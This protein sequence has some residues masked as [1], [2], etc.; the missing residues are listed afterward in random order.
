MFLM[1]HHLRD[2][3]PDDPFLI[4]TAKNI[5][6]VWV[7]IEWKCWSHENGNWRINW[8]P[9]Q[10]CFLEMCGV[11]GK[12]VNAEHK[13]HLK[14]RVETHEMNI[15][16]I[17]CK[18]SNESKKRTQPMQNPVLVSFRVIQTHGV[19]VDSFW[20]HYGIIKDK[21]VYGFVLGSVKNI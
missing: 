7:I 17:W 8:N 3:L 14:F 4:R 12:T 15:K 19:E 18:Q 16:G 2:Y 11:C 1:K 13:S 20:Y 6:I 9:D 5:K 10:S 21:H